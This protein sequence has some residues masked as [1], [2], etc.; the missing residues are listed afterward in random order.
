MVKGMLTS[1]LLPVTVM[2]MFTAW[3]MLRRVEW[4]LCLAVRSPA[5]GN[6]VMAMEARLKADVLSGIEPMKAMVGA[7][8]ARAASDLRIR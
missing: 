1:R 5:T 7:M 4:R 6:G 2:G 3:A 8:A